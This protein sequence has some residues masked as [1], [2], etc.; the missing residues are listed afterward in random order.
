MAVG[1]NETSQTSENHLLRMYKVD[2]AQKDMVASLFSK[3]IDFPIS[4]VSEKGTNTQLVRV[5]PRFLGNGHFVVSA[6]EGIHQG[7][8]EL[9]NVL[10]SSEPPPSTK[11]VEVNYWF[12]LGYHGERAQ[13]DTRLAEISEALKSLSNL[14]EM[15]FELLEKIRSMSLD[16]HRSN[17]RGVYAK[18]DTGTSIEGDK[19]EL[20][21]DINITTEITSAKLR[22][23]IQLADGKFGIMGESG[24]VFTFDKKERGDKPT[25]FYVVQAKILD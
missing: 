13:P 8:E 25:L 15:R 18:V 22:T 4:V 9:V 19:I 21:T 10:K 5:R 12:V 11:T 23:V 14:G 16:G 3:G 7:I 24:F 17:A 20:T 2:P 1:T 6:P